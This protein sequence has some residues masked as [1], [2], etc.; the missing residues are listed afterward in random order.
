MPRVDLV[1]GG[2]CPNVAA[3]RARLLEAFQLA[4]VVPRWSEHVIGD[5]RAPK[6]VRGFGSPTILVDGRDV[7][8]V[9]AEAEA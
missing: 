6:R 8:G 4:R 2:E 5:A 3:A 7:A 9:V 1:F